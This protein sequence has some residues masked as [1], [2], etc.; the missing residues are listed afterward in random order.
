[1][2]IKYHK[3]FRKHFKK[4][5]ANNPKLVNQFEKRLN[6]LILDQSNPLLR[7]HSLKG[8]RQSYW[9]FSITG[10]IRVIYKKINN[11]IIQLY[12]IGSHNQVY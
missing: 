11:N 6:E 2:T 9:S 3:T 8:S 7:N 1:M 5:I 12:D 4:R 10:D